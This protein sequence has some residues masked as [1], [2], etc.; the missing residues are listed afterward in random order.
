M[1]VKAKE[2]GFYGC[3]RQQGEVFEVAD[4]DV[5]KDAW[6]TPVGKAK[7]KAS[8]DAQAQAEADAASLV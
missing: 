8:A 5:S 7:A 1:Q 4:S 6:F 3:Y 2:D